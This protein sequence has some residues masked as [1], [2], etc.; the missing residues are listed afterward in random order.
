[1]GSGPPSGGS[2]VALVVADTADLTIALLL[3]WAT[4]MLGDRPFLRAGS[5]GVFRPQPDGLIQLDGLANDGGPRRFSS[6]RPGCVRACSSGLPVQA[7]DVA[8]PQPVVD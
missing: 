5:H 3:S 7:A 6:P 8:I 2:L 1:M 4:E